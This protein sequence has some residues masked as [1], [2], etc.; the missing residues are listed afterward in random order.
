MEGNIITDQEYQSLCQG[1]FKESMVNQ[2]KALVANINSRKRPNE[3]KLDYEDLK[4]S[5][6]F[7]IDYLLDGNLNIADDNQREEVSRAVLESLER[8]QRM[9]E[10]P[11]TW[12]AGS[13]KRKNKRRN[14][15]KKRKINKTKNKR[16][17]S[18]KTK[19]YRK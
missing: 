13:K 14:T 16:R 19:N 8:V 4:A 7:N 9:R 3:E 15:H 12:L 1:G 5:L 2:L 18:K 10:R 11:T 17:M 6:D